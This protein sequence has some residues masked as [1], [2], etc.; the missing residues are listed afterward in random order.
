MADYTYQFLEKWQTD[1]K[2]EEINSRW[3]KRQMK[4]IADGKKAD[5]KIADSKIADKTK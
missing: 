2:A 3:K 1:M 5:E 4:K